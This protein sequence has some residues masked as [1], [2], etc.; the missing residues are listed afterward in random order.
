M[1]SY[2]GNGYE[3]HIW[4][5]VLHNG[6]FSHTA[7]RQK[8]VHASTEEAV[9]MAVTIKP[10]YEQEVHDGFILTVGREYIYSV[11]Y[12]GRPEYVVRYVKDDEGDLK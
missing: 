11:T 4:A 10:G 5:T 6:K 1:S 12:L 8:I 3:V 7:T 2:Q 9:R